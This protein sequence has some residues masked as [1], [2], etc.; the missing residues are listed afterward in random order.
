MINQQSNQHLKYTI[1]QDRIQVENEKNQQL[2][3]IMTLINKLINKLEFTIS[4]NKNKRSSSKENF[5]LP[6]KK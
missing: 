1:K 3:N 2:I 5:I 4:F 6:K